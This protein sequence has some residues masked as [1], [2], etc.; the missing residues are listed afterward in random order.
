MFY[1][2]TLYNAYGFSFLKWF[3]EAFNKKDLSLFLFIINIK[4]DPYLPV[5][6]LALNYESKG[7]VSIYLSHDC[8][9]PPQ[10]Q[11]QCRV[12]LA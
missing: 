4:R 1:S 12:L 8:M 6:E 3:D 2:T 7:K 5:M 9:K 11:I 10:P